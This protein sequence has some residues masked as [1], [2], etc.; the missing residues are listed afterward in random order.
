MRLFLPGQRRT[1]TIELPG[2]SAA[3]ARE[4]ARSSLDRRPRPSVRLGPDG[5]VRFHLPIRARHVMPRFHGVLRDGDAGAM[6]SGRV[7]EARYEGFLPAVYA[8]LT[9]VMTAGAVASAVAG[10]VTTLVL[11][12]VGAVAFG[13]LSVALRAARVTAFRRDLVELEAALRR[14]FGAPETVP[15]AQPKP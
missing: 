10:F 7:R 9:V 13:I 11:L 3:S 6:L 14:S 12:A 2:I 15:R 8:V 4:T 1:L 5:S